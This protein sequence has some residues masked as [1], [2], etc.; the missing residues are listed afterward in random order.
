MYCSVF[1]FVFLLAIENY[2]FSV[3]KIENADSPYWTI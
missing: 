1:K 2:A 3:N